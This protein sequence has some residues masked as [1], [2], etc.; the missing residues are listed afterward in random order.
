MNDSMFS[1]SLSYCQGSREAVFLLSKHNFSFSKCYPFVSRLS[2][3]A[4]FKM[5][6]L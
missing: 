3:E 2:H 5:K 4:D 6:L 1:P